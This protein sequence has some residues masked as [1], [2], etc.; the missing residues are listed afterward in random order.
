MDVVVVGAGVIGLSAAIRLAEGGAR[1]RVWAAELPPRTTSAAAGALWGP[2]FAEPGFGWSLVTRDELAGLAGE[3][4]TGVRFCRGRQVSD[5]ATEPPPWIGEL[6][7]VEMIPAEELTDGM[8]VGLWTTAPV[9]DMPVYLEYLTERLGKAGVEIEQRRVRSLAEAAATAPAVVNCTGMGARELAGDTE[10]HPVRGQ[11]VVVENP[12]IEEF[13]L[14]ARSATE[15]AGY[16]PHG[17][18]VVLGGVAG[19]D[20]WNTEPDPAVA[21]GILER[22]ARIEPRL[23]GARVIEHRVGLRPQRT[24][25]RMEVEE[26]DGA[27]IVHDYGHGGMGVSLSWGTAKAVCELLG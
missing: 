9:V 26:R 13:Y 1:V 14:E 17:G 24:P 3:P 5:L 25:Y 20:D 8:L 19:L 7:D 21:R 27:R 2:D 23:D 10:L 22:C 11:H 4:G 12:G 18:H 15:W 16:F 6:R